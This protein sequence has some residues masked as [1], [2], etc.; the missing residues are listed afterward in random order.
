[1]TVSWGIVISRLNT[2][3][4]G[5]FNRNFYFV[6]I[7]V[8]Q[9]NKVNLFNNFKVA[10]MK[11]KSIATICC[12]LVA[13]LFCLNTN[14]YASDNQ[15][16]N[17]RNDYASDSCHS[18]KS[19][20]DIQETNA[21]YQE[22]LEKTNTQLS[23]WW[24]PYG[25]IISCLAVLFTIGAIIAAIIIF[26]Q[27]S[28]HR[29]L[30]ENSLDEHKKKLNALI[31]E[32]NNYLKKQEIGLDNLI[33]EFKEKL[34][35]VDENQ[36]N[37]IELVINK[38]SNQRD[39]IDTE[40]RTFKHSGWAHRDIY[41]DFRLN[42][43]S[44][45]YARIVLHK[46]NQSFVIYF[47]IVTTDGKRF[48][49]GFAGNNGENTPRKTREEYKLQETYGTE[50]N[51][52]VIQRNIWNLFSEGFPEIASEPNSIDCIRLR[53]SNSDPGEIAFTYKIQ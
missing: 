33:C 27:G 2:E 48:W 42:P 53:G 19:C 47:R 39:I 43:D 36:K 51:R 23:L 22:I 25:V 8:N 13:V 7:V 30:I 52:V 35:T 49:I 26:K 15:S 50:T 40:L 20:E 9:I 11:S 4:N 3:T 29:R 38:L 12:V 34:S 16:N 5:Q 10:S 24:N 37:Q 14:C 1:M 46:P 31:E 18:H 17:K 45:I 6:I 21:Q 28:E 44:I 41:E 32:K